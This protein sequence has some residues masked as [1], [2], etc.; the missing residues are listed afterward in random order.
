M[1]RIVCLSIM[2]ASAVIL[3]R[4]AAAEDFATLTD[5]VFGDASC[6]LTLVDDAGRALETRATFDVCDEAL[7]LIG[8]RVRLSHGTATIMAP[9]CEG[10]PACSDVEQVDLVTGIAPAD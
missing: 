3:A 8:Q 10:D 2:A 9:S 6:Y 5:A 7:D 4:T 1:L